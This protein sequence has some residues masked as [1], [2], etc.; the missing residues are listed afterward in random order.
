MFPDGSI[1]WQCLVTWIKTL[2]FFSGR[3]FCLIHGSQ[4]CGVYKNILHPR[5]SEILFICLGLKVFYI[6]VYIYF[7][8]IPFNKGGG[9]LRHYQPGAWSSRLTQRP[10]LR[11]FSFRVYSHLEGG[12]DHSVWARTGTGLEMLLSS[13]AFSILVSSLRNV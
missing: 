3:Y 4:Y 11:H 6:N 1:F 10:G 12:G 7:L 9:L 5:C 13:R 8:Q 2:P